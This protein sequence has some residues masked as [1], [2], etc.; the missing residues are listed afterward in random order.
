M[1]FPGIYYFKQ[2]KTDL[3]VTI[4]YSS[5]YFSF[6]IL[7]LTCNFRLFCDFCVCVRVLSPVQLFV[8]PWTTARQVLLSMEFSRQEYWSELPF[9][10]PGGISWPKDQTCVSCI[11]RQI[12]LSLCHLGSLRARI[13]A[14]LF[15]LCIQ[16]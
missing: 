9:P 7:N 8:T 16:Y 10:S 14:V 11:G 3:H 12:L 1:D 4:S 15:Y 5:K 13:M 2:L 6:M